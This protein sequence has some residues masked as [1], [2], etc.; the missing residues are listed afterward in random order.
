[1]SF[2]ISIDEEEGVSRVDEDGAMRAVRDMNA[3]TVS[4]YQET[5]S[6]T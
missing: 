4:R 2:L 1:M 5:V 3:L 6:V